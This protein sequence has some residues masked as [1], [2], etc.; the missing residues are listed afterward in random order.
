MNK[1][2]YVKLVAE[3]AGLTQKQAEAAYLAQ[4]EVIQETL[5]A[6]DKVALVGF[7]TYELKS[8]PAREV[9]NPLTKQK[10][11]IPASEVPSFKFGKA[12]KE[13]F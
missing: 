1:T 3:K 9:F 5:K 4:L 7:G 6:G 12:F 10:Q 8:K 11:S 13:L 2:E